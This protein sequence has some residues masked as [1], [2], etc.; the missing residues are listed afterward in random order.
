MQKVVKRFVVSGI[1]LWFAG[2]A[3]FLWVSVE[4]EKQQQYLNQQQELYNAKLVE[5]NQ[6]ANTQEEINPFRVI[7]SEAIKSEKSD[8]IPQSS[9]GKTISYFSVICVASGTI[10]FLSLLLLWLVHFTIEKISN[11]KKNLAQFR[12]SRKK[13]ADVL[14]ESNLQK[15]EKTADVLIESNSQKKE[16]TAKLAQKLY[17]PAKFDPSFSCTDERK[18]HPSSTKVEKHSANSIK[19][20]QHDKFFADK[21]DFRIKPIDNLEKNI[22]DAIRSSYHENAMKAQDSF[23][24]QADKLEKQV[25]E[26]K[27]LTQAITQASAGNDKPLDNNIGE[28]AEQLSAIRDYAS[29]QQ[30]RV[31]KLQEGYDWNIIRTFCLRVIRCI[32]NID[33]RIDSISQQGGDTSDLEDIKDDLVF[34]LESSGVEQFEPDIN[35]KYAS[36]QKTAEAVKQKKSC[37]EPEMKGKIAEIIKPGYRYVIDE[38]NTKIVRTAQVKLFG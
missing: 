7:I 26:I 11:F 36:S 5:I 37:G 14:I 29:S 17:E 32:D 30:D 23:K 22:R 19:P 10:I 34:V 20:D 33:S 13:T 4:K 8:N 15:R 27:N 1:I 28:L 38:D 6:L 24:Q 16:K 31:T 25:V 2:A 9:N 21:S 3:S 35:S 18:F 12:K